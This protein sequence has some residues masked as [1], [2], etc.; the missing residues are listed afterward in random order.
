M[1]PAPAIEIGLRKVFAT[2]ARSSVA[3]AETPGIARPI[4]WWM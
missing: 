1:N 2:Y 4:D 3:Q